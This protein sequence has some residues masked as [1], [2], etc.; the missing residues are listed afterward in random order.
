MWFLMLCMCGLDFG[1]HSVIMQQSDVPKMLCWTERYI[2][3]THK[4]HQ[5][6]ST[7]EAGD[8][9]GQMFLAAHRLTHRWPLLLCAAAPRITVLPAEFSVMVRSAF[10]HSPRF[11]S[12][13]EG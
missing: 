8:E 10:W 11:M 7:V 2:E 6:R 5:V 4:S 3:N 12:S 1:F 13:W 9:L